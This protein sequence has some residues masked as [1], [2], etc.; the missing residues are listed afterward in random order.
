MKGTAEM[1]QPK[2]TLKARGDALDEGNVWNDSQGGGEKMG[3][4]VL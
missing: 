2:R 4:L 1:I 3:D